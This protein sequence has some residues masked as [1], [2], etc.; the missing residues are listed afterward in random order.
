MFD[1]CFL[2]DGGQRERVEDERRK[3]VYVRHIPS[4]LRDREFWRL[5]CSSVVGINGRRGVPQPQLRARPVGS[6]LLFFIFSFI[7]PFI[8]S[9]ACLFIRS[10]ICS[11]FFSYPCF[12]CVLFQ[13]LGPYPFACFLDFRRRQVNALFIKVLKMMADDRTTFPCSASLINDR[14][15]RE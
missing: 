5:S 12:L 8:Y 4:P 10:F 6:V 1:L 11:C 9:L 7:H 15:K 13:L 14:M 2:A 3:G